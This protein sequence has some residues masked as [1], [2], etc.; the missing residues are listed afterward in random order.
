MID[1]YLKDKVVTIH[2][3][4]RGTFSVPYQDS[5]GE[6]VNIDN[7]IELLNDALKELENTSFLATDFINVLKNLICIFSGIFLSILLNLNNFIFLSSAMPIIGIIMG[8]LQDYR[9]KKEKDKKLE[10]LNLQKNYIIDEINKK[11]SQKAIL[12]RNRA[13]ECLVKEEVIVLDKIAKRK[14]LLQSTLDLLMDYKLHQRYFCKNFDNKT[15]G[16][17]LKTE[18]EKRLIQDVIVKERRR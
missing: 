4:F 7:D 9:Y 5:I 12:E 18:E 16:N 11:K 17:I 15:L 10:G 13:Q 6:I 1:R 14:A 8:T 3:D 2:D